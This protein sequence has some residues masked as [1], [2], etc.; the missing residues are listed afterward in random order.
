MPTSWKVFLIYLTVEK[1]KVFLHNES[2]LWSSTTVVFHGL[3][4][5]LVLLSS[6]EHSCFL[7]MYKTVYFDTPN[8][9]TI[10]LMNL[11]RLFRLTMACITGINT[12]L[13]LR[14]RDTSSRI[15]MR[16]PLLE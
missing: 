13:V 15:Q 9:L 11:F 2:I 6:P 1:G 3:V 10:S 5:C 8:I 16:M 12:S 7:T 4:G 14:L